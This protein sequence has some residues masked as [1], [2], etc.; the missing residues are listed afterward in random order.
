M[1]RGSIVDSV[2]YTMKTRTNNCVLFYMY[3]YPI[4]TMKLYQ[5]KIQNKK[6]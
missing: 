5:H 1:Y 6:R 3:K 4:Y 2:G